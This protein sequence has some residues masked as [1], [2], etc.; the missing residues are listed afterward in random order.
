MKSA[1]CVVA[2]FMAGFVAGLNALCVRYDVV[3]YRDGGW[4]KLVFVVFL[5][6]L[7]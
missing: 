5:G 3:Q 2:V 7:F 1:A 4:G 6:V